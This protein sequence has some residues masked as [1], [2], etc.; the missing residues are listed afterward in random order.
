[1]T[2]CKD[3]MVGGKVVEQSVSRKS[4]GASVVML[5]ASFVA[6]GATVEMKSL[7]SMANGF[8]QLVIHSPDSGQNVPP[9]QWL[10]LIWFNGVVDPGDAD[11]LDS[12]PVELL[13]MRN[14]AVEAAFSLYV[15]NIS[16]PIA[17]DIFAGDLPR[18]EVQLVLV[19]DR[20][21]ASERRSKPVTI[22]VGSL[23]CAMTLE[24]AGDPEH[25]YNWSGSV[26]VIN[27][28]TQGSADWEVALSWRPEDILL[29]SASVES[30]DAGVR[31][32]KVSD[33]EYKLT[34]ADAAGIDA[35]ESRT[36]RVLGKGISAT[37]EVGCYL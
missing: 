17:A 3:W 11:G 25:L 14:G 28:G 8:D 7:D 9:D 37:P 6:V 18:G 10:T 16:K 27:D 19:V 23:P 33:T 31:M 13:A 30:P 20:E 34:G 24:T 26:T 5:F 1:M 22:N 21:L 29:A 15:S 32:E 2:R 36:Y 4:L 35:G 12:K